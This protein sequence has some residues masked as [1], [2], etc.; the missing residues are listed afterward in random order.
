MWQ[1][2]GLNP[3]KKSLP[4]KLFHRAFAERCKIDLN[5]MD[6]KQHIST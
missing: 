6:G 4:G 3:L 5:P 1:M 2:N